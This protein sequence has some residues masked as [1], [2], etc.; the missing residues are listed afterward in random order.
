MI[1]TDR[2]KRAYQKVMSVLLVCLFVISGCSSGNSG[3]SASPKQVLL[4]AV[5]Y[6][7]QQEGFHEEFDNKETSED[8]VRH[9]LS[10]SYI[11]FPS[12]A[13]YQVSFQNAV[14]G[15]YKDIYIGKY[16]QTDI[17][18]IQGTPSSTSFRD[19]TV[20]NLDSYEGRNESFADRQYFT[21]LFEM[22]TANDVSEQVSF[23]M[24]K[25]DEGY[26]ITITL[27][28]IDR[29]NEINR[30]KTLEEYGEDWYDPYL[31]FCMTVQINKGIIQK[32]TWDEKANRNGVIQDRVSTATY[33]PCS[34]DQ[35][36]TALIDDLVNQVKV[37][38]ISEN[39]YLTL[40][41]IVR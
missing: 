23:E 14:G 5:E 34:I 29:F 11:I 7:N 33:T 2:M 1:G 22:F 31:E 21:S 4:D 30:E 19:M 8:G 39:S 35:V 16:T 28:D 37:G 15:S 3:A 9:T 10:D 41:G 6:S 32:V 20:T 40:E 18:Y 24:E 27:T 25:N 12:Q 36:D 26:R 38:T 13:C 17:A